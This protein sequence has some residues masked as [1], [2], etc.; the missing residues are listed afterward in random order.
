LIR[1]EPTTATRK[2]LLRAIY[3]KQSALKS[4]LI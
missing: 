1:F 2:T 4:R 3:V